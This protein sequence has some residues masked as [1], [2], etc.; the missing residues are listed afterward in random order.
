MTIKDDQISEYL[1]ALIDAMT[2]NTHQ[3][4]LLI[5]YRACPALVPGFEDPPGAMAAYNLHQAMIVL[6]TKLGKY[7]DAM[8][9]LDALPLEMTLVDTADLL[10]EFA[11]FRDSAFLCPPPVV[12][13]GPEGAP[14][15]LSAETKEKVRAFVED[16]NLEEHV[17]A[18][19]DDECAPVVRYPL[20]KD[21]H[22]EGETFLDKRPEVVIVPSPRPEGT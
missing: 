5:A 19:V 14:S 12:E 17:S 3:Q 6:Q 22:V 10:T 20:A 13:R 8:A 2:E 7:V 21:Q 11:A 15:P 16:L 1:R 18:S 4:A 9:T